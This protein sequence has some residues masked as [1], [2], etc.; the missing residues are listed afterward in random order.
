MQ[1]EPAKMTSSHTGERA[2]WLR[3]GKLPIILSP[4]STNGLKDDASEVL[5]D[6]LDINLCHLCNTAQLPV[7]ISPVSQKIL[8]ICFTMAVL[9]DEHNFT[10][11]HTVQ[12][13]AIELRVFL[14]PHYD[15]GAGSSWWFCFADTGV[16]LDPLCKLCMFLPL[17]CMGT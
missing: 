12:T 2:Q 5:L 14:V 17:W 13:H 4:V 8:F 16:T 11:V 9:T 15:L 7:L 10:T 6:L 1:R 3:L